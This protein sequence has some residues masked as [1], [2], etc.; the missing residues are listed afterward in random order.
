GASNIGAASYEMERNFISNI[1]VGYEITDLSGD[2]RFGIRKDWPQ[3][4]TILQKG[5]DAITREE[6]NVILNKWLK[7]AVKND[8]VANLN[9]TKEEL[10]FLKKH[11]ILKV[12]SELDYAPWDFVKDGESMGY[13]V[14]Y[15]KLLASKLGIKVEFVQD[16]WSELIKKIENKE[17]DIAHSMY[18]NNSRK[19]VSY[20]N[21]YKTV[22]NAIFVHEENSNIKSS[23]DLDF[24]SISIPK[25]DSIIVSLQKN[26]PNAKIIE[27]DGYLES[28]KN[29]AF[30][31]SDATVFDMAVA[32]YLINEFTIPS[33]KIVDQIELTANDVEYYSYRL[34]VRDDYPLL[35][36]ILNKTMKSLN[37]DELRKINN[38]WLLAP[39]QKKTQIRLQLSKDEQKW[40]E[41]KEPVQYAYDVDWAPFE[42]KDDIGEHTGIIADIIKIISNKSG[43]KFI[44]NN[45]V[46]NWDEALDAAKTKKVDM[47]SGTGVSEDKLKYLNFT[48]KNIYTVPY[49]VITRIDDNAD[50]TDGF[51]MSEKRVFGLIKG[52]SLVDKVSQNHK[53]LS[54]ILVKDTQ[55]G[56]DK[57]ESEEIDAFVINQ[58]TANYYIKSLGYDKLRIA[59]KLSDSL[60]LK[61]GIRNDWPKDV[62]SILDKTLAEISDEELHSIFTKWTNKKITKEPDYSLIWKISLLLIAIVLL[63]AFYNRKLQLLVTQKTAQ[64]QSTIK[65]FDANV[66]ASNTDLKGKIT[67][68]SDAF[69]EISGYT[70]EEMMGKPHN[71][72]RHPDMPKESF[73]DLW[74]TIKSGKTWNGEVKNIKKNGGY[75]WVDAVVSPLYNEKNEIIG[76]SSIRH[77]ITAKKEVEE[78]SKN[79]E[80]KVEERTLDLKEAQ[81]QFT[82]MVSNVPG[83][84]Y[85]VKD[86]SS[87]PII[88][89]SD[90]IEKITGYPASDFMEN[91]IVTFSTIMYHDDVEPIG[92][93]IQEQFSKGRSFQVDYRV[94][95]KS[96]EI[97]W[98][99]SQGQSVKN[100]EGDSYIDGVLI[101]IT[102]QK[103]L[104]TLIKQ[105]QE[106]MVF[107]SEYA[108]LGFWTFNPQVGDLL[109]ND[110][111]VKMLGYDANEV[112]LEGYEKEMFKPF[113]DG[114]AFW[115]ELLHPDDAQRTGE[116]INAHINGETELYKVEYR[117][118]KADGSWMWS[119]A[120]GRIAEYDSD[121]KAIKFNGVNLDIQ[122][123]KDAQEEIAQNKLFVDTLLDSQEQIV[124]TT[125]GKTL[126][127]ANKKFLE[128]FNIKHTE[129][130]TK[131][132]DCICDRFVIDETGTYLQKYMGEISWIE[133]VL[134]NSNKTHKAVILKDDKERI[135]SVTAAIMP[136]EDG[137]IK[138]AVFTDITELEF[139]KKQTDTILSSVLLPMLITSKKTKKIVYANTFAEKQYDTTMDELIGLDIDA[140][141]TSESQR[142]QILEE[143]TSKGILEN[144]ETKFKTLKGR[145]FDA[146]LSLVDISFGG[147]DCFLG[148]ASD[149]TQQK[150][151]QKEIQLIHK[152]TRE[153]IEYASLI[154]HS[155]IPS[156]DLF[157]KYFNDYLTI[158][159]PKDV[160]GGDIYLFEELRDDNECILMVID[161]TGHGV[162]GAFVTMLVKAIERQIT[163]NIIN[164]DEVVSPAKIL[165]IFNKSMKHLLK[166]ED[167][168]SISNAGF[169]GGIIYY[170]KKDKIIKFA[171]AETPLFYLEDGELKTIKGSR[172]SVGYKKSDAN[173]E[174]KEHT[175]EVKEGMQF[176]LTTDGYLD[177]NG[178]DKGFPFGKKRFSKILEE[179]YGLPFADQQELLLYDMQD[180][181]GNEERND[182]VTIVGIKI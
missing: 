112:L 68:V 47:L 7:L 78:L 103:E 113:K 40:L 152:H 80:H 37:E 50:F 82:S 44:P 168:H 49:V 139:Q 30:K 87:W 67:Y 181:Q 21:K 102:E 131:D 18:K 142:S 59:A 111:F 5:I 41:K 97:I 150:E 33:L 138:S 162:P 89:M 158:W 81:K 155:L 57:L 84:I 32:N 134:N 61:I 29:V 6:I 132:Y 182:D 161:C 4:A 17:I 120:I 90:E 104:E 174:F 115:A 25:G 109:V 129:E 172:H 91:K 69:C 124:I 147:E 36:S 2:M 39:I 20:T 176:Y 46:Q 95:S 35:V 146:I 34:G 26:F 14:D 114:L 151:L 11:P 125:D 105:N 122:D 179:N 79:L 86:D 3:L 154:Q 169:D 52:H 106:Q 180:Y 94:I 127:S 96:G 24:K 22:I 107:V 88:Y 8:N 149:I 60:E 165:Q 70:Q 101:D 159:H 16:R 145:E 130:F 58:A 85:R 171:G 13:S 144:F 43:I 177:Q 143:L 99:R 62:I 141:Y 108:N 166:Q 42:W 27:P 45:S 157:R 100:D 126:R 71:I 160:V 53:N 12:S 156:N 63:F 98:V 92:Q 136:I 56:F 133:Y 66:I 9:L 128:F 119:M 64:L 77:D 110:T 1:K 167:E 164:S 123:A 137:I 83:A 175:I 65:L 10:E 117:M 54:V 76:Y 118:K 170:N 73:K 116:I 121:G 93:I 51:N 38:K 148:V 55:D 72:S 178:G 28:L 153:S 140:F 23:K 173:F 135:F 163:S 74:Q 31:K 19:G 75:Y 15:V 48:N